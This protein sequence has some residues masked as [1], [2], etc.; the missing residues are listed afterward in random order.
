MFFADHIE[1]L[2]DDLL[3]ISEEYGDWKTHGASSTCSLS[4]SGVDSS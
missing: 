2:G 3:V 4:T 1:V